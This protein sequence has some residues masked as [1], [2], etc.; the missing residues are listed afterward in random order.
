VEAAS[1]DVSREPR[2]G[3]RT[4]PDGTPEKDHKFDSFQNT[5]EV[6]QAY[7]YILTHPGVPCV[8]WKHYFDWGQ[9]LQN[10]IRALVNARKVA[11]V[12]SGSE[13]VLQDNARS[14]GVYAARVLGRAG[15]LFVRVGA[16]KRTGSRPTPGLPTT[17]SMPPA[18]GGASGSASRATR[19]IERRRASRRCRSGLPAAGRHRDS[20]CLVE[21]VNGW[22]AMR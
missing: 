12:H 4:N 21:P 1:G 17:A 15:D 9:D 19:R 2:H 16:R 22:A 7:A 14:R 6:E 5:W 20:G 13:I 11:G 3:Y 8:Y 10:K 18:P